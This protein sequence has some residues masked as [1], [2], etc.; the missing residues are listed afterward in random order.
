MCLAVAAIF[1][2]ANLNINALIIICLPAP[3]VAVRSVSKQVQRLSWCVLLLFL[4]LLII[5]SIFKYLDFLAALDFIN[6]FFHHSQSRFFSSQCV[7]INTAKRYDD[8]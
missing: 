8:M 4:F 6:N 2:A 1:T 5:C 7:R 3:A